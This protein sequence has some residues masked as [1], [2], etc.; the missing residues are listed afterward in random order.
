MCH[1]FAD[2]VSLSTDPWCRPYVSN[3]VNDLPTSD[4]STSSSSA[5]SLG[6][7]MIKNGR[8]GIVVSDAGPELSEDGKPL[9]PNDVSPNI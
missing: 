5:E 3:G 2:N 7:M 4:G 6:G 9:V 1:S 8:Y